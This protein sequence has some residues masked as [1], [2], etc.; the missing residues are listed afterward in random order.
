MTVRHYIDTQDFTKEEMLNLVDLGLLIKKTIKS[1][2]HLNVLYQKTLGMIF[3][4][5]STRTRVSF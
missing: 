5:K 4:Q 2:G 3:E 1:G